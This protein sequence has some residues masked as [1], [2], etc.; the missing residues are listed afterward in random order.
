[1]KKATKIAEKE[2]KEP[3]V[4]KVERKWKKNFSVNEIT[5]TTENVRKSLEIIQS[6]LTNSIKNK[7]KTEAWKEIT[8]RQRS[9][10]GEPHD[11][12]S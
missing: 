5:V 1:M 2:M 7:R 10:S 12:R 6:K 4:T 8:K 11:T 3:E 9:G